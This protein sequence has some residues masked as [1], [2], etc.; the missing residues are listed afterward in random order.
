MLVAFDNLTMKNKLIKCKYKYLKLVKI[1]PF[2]TLND[3]IY[4]R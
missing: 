3:I 4:D 2:K 1:N